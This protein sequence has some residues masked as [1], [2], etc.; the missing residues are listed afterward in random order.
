MK[1]VA[2]AQKASFL[3]SGIYFALSAGSFLQV[4]RLFCAANVGTAVMFGLAVFYGLSAAG[5]VWYVARLHAPISDS[6]SR[7][8]LKTQRA[9]RL[10]ALSVP[11][12]I[13]V[14]AVLSNPTLLTQLPTE[15]AVGVMDTV[16]EIATVVAGPDSSHAYFSNAF[17]AL[18]TSAERLEKIGQYAAAQSFYETI[19]KLRRSYGILLPQNY[20]TMGSILDRQHE[21]AAAD[22]YFATAE[23]MDKAHLEAQQFGQIWFRIRPEGGSSE[24]TSSEGATSKGPS[25][26][27]GTS[28]GATSEGASSI[29]GPNENRDATVITGVNTNYDVVA[30]PRML[31]LLSQ[32]DDKRALDEF[33]FAPKLLSERSASSA[34]LGEQFLHIELSPTVRDFRVQEIAPESDNFESMDFARGSSREHTAGYVLRGFELRSRLS[35]IP[36][37]TLRN[38]LPQL[39]PDHP[40]LHKLHNRELFTNQALAGA[41]LKPVCPQELVREEITILDEK[42]MNRLDKLTA[43][44]N[45]APQR[46]RTIEARNE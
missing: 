41:H 14:L 32:V 28:N 7:M 34:V 24:G 18:T 11:A 21:Y 29:E 25:S 15:N 3:F 46:S 27:S 6:S 42:T 9:I 38:E 8:G 20:A 23:R 31:R 10:L 33:D 12:P 13:I 17:K 43:G 40:F 30:A 44:S 1:Q 5:A 36:F 45:S 26:E 4:A 35:H 2:P 22:S 19:F 16:S 39:L 37:E